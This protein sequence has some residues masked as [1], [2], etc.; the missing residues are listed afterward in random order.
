MEGYQEALVKRKELRHDFDQWV[1]D[2]GAKRP[3]KTQKKQM[4]SVWLLGA[5]GNYHNTLDD[6][7]LT[8]SQSRYDRLSKQHQG[9]DET[10]AL[11]LELLLLRYAPLSKGLQ[12]AVPLAV[13]HLL[14]KE[15]E[16]SCECFSSPL[17]CN[18]ASFC[19]AFPEDAVFGSMGS[20]FDFFPTEGSF[21][22]NPPFTTVS[23]ERAFVHM[24][25]LLQSDGGAA[26]QFIV[27]VPSW[28]NQDCWKMLSNSPFNARSVS[29]KVREH[30]YVHSSTTASKDPRL[31]RGVEH[32]S[33][34]GTTVFFL[35][36]EAARSR[37][38]VSDIAVKGLRAAFGEDRLKKQ[39]KEKRKKNGAMTAKEWFGRRKK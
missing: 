25:K 35:Q 12:A 11:D 18:L 13:C 27:I 9:T 34:N 8:L 19:S 39:T 4:P 21:E 29:L 37:Y 30:V 32:R 36:N 33:T 7:T 38:V 2:E 1:F 22:V 3:N 28:K 26:L 23:I 16:V 17:N 31:V 10:F 15:W 24:T 5:D 20:F 14:N 6:V